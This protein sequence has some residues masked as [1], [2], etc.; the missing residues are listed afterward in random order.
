[1][2]LAG[3]PENSNV[4]GN[5]LKD[6]IANPESEWPNAAITTYGRNNHAIRTKDYRYIR[7][8]DGSEELYDRRSDENEWYNVVENKEYQ[9]VKENLRKHL[10]QENRKWSK[11]SKYNFNEYLTKQRQEQVEE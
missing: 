4:E 9:E 1:V 5:S 2:D 8:E 6:L 3:L 7:Y 10:P 11:A